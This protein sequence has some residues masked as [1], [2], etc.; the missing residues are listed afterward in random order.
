MPDGRVIYYD[1]INKKVRELKSDPA[2]FVPEDAPAGGK[3]EAKPA[4]PKPTG[5]NP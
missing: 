4:A 1:P 3:A 5:E 2:T